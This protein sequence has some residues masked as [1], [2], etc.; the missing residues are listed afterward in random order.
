MSY[1]DGLNCIITDGSLE[2]GYIEFPV[3]YDDMKF[4][5]KSSLHTYGVSVA[6]LHQVQFP[7]QFFTI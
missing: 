4:R 5:L 1:I 6:S 7:A 2:M 3:R